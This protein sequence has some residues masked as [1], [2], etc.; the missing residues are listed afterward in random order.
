MRQRGA[1]YEPT[2]PAKP[3][4]L[5][6]GESRIVGKSSRKDSR[7]SAARPQTLR[8]TETRLIR[9]DRANG[10]SHHDGGIGRVCL[11]SGITKNSPGRKIDVDSGLA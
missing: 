10:P 1:V 11:M 4:P 2:T 9:V 5:A 7:L 6:G 8:G 3:W